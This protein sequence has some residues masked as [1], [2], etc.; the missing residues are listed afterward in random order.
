MSDLRLIR[1]Q[2]IIE[3]NYDKNFKK[4]DFKGKGKSD[5]WQK[6]DRKKQKFSPFADNFIE[7]DTIETSDQEKAKPMSRR[8]KQ[9]QDFGR[10][11]RNRN[12]EDF[13]KRD[14]KKYNLTSG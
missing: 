3:F 12:K 5:R 8:G 13:K 14:K 2:K 1:D 10:S 4:D 11:D 9:K 7:K 6:S